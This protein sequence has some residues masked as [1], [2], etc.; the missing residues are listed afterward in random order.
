MCNGQLTDNGRRDYACK[1]S[2]N[3]QPDS[4]VVTPSASHAEYPGSIPGL[5]SQSTIQKVY[6]PLMR[7]NKPETRA[8][9]RHLVGI[10]CLVL[11]SLTNVN[12][13]QPRTSTTNAPTRD[14]DQQFETNRGDSTT[15][16]PTTESTPSRS[17]D[18]P[19]KGTAHRIL[20]RWRVGQPSWKMSTRRRA[21]R[22]FGVPTV[23]QHPS[24]PT[25]YDY[26]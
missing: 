6:A 14:A 20:A 3:R 11:T 23:R 1:H 9:A 13:R 16:E 19:S 5:V 8:R 15:T 21:A 26:N 18:C 4:L 22:Q 7:A 17:A 12:E 2:S 25:T 24:P 10:T